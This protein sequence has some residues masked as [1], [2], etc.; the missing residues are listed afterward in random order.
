MQRRNDQITTST[1]QH[2]SYTQ[3]IEDISLLLVRRLVITVFEYAGLFTEPTTRQSGFDPTR[4]KCHAHIYVAYKGTRVIVM[5]ISGDL[6]RLVALATPNVLCSSAI[7]N[8]KHRL[9]CKDNDNATQPTA[10]S[11]QQ[12]LRATVLV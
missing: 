7:E 12:T 3:S 11:I 6:S 2:C 4:R 8:R 5:L 9:C 1:R 10:D